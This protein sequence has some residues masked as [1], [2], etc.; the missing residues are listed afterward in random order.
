[1]RGESIRGG[2]CEVSRTPARPGPSPSASPLLREPQ[3]QH[4]SRSSKRF[5]V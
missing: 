2:P 5:N 1:M 4:S 3:R